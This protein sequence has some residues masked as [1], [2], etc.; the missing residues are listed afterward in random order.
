[1]TR[2]DL[3]TLVFDAQDRDFGSF[4]SDQQLPDEVMTLFLAGGMKQPPTF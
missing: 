4:M 3:L 2:R 1:M